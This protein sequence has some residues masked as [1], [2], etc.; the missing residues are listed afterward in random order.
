[1]TVDEYV[2]L[3]AQMHVL[4]LEEVPAWEIAVGTAD[5]LP[6]GRATHG[7]WSRGD[8]SFLLSAWAHAGLV[9][10]LSCEGWPPRERH[11]LQ[12]SEV[13][14]VLS[15]HARWPSL[16]RKDGGRWW[17]LFATER[18]LAADHPQWVSLA[19]SLS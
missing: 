9:G 16:P 18:G 14:Q 1:M 3:M 13:A 11:E 12:P 10:I 15:A 4:V 8:C 17:S 6:A 19:P 2:D 5:V 7:P